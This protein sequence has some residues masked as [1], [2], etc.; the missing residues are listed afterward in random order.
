MWQSRLSFVHQM[1]LLMV[2]IAGVILVV[3]CAVFHYEVQSGLLTKDTFLFI[4]S[5][6]TGGFLFF[7]V[8]T[9]AWYKKK[10]Y[11]YISLIS[12]NL[13]A[14][15]NGLPLERP[16]K[17]LPSDL[18][19]LDSSAQQVLSILRDRDRILDRTGRRCVAADIRYETLFKSAADPVFIGDKDGLLICNPRFEELTGL[20]SE[21]IMGVPLASL[22]I[23]L[24]D[25]E[26]CQSLLVHWNDVKTGGARFNWRFTNHEK[27]EIILDVNLRFV[28]IEGMCL[29]FCI[30]RDITCEEK[31]LHKQEQL[32]RQID[33]NMA[34]LAALND[35]IR[36]PLTLITMS[37]GFVEDP[38]QGKI[39]EGARLIDD[40]VH[41]L[42]KGFIESD[43]VRRF[44]QK[45]ITG[46]SR[47]EDEMLMEQADHP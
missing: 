15:V 41:R 14:G 3:I 35:Q 39:L 7:L 20:S 12:R 45:A 36:N 10:Y 26:D 28:K 46:F 38:Y 18:V 25:A 43:K 34:Q 5:I 37:A 22:P 47:G 40:L 1:V 16:E 24:S 27:K 11:Q 21:T 17:N 8:F 9:V 4:T 31:L 23:C 32:I 42:D 2:L 44:L 33:K 6:I 29:R 19:P 13:S 30:G